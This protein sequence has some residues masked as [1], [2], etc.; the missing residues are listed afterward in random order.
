MNTDA[1]RTAEEPSTAF[2]A[3]AFDILGTLLRTADSPGTL[4]VYLTQQM[5]E[6][7]GAR[8]C[9]LLQSLHD[10]DE[11]GH[12]VVSVH[13]EGRGKLAESAEVRRLANLANDLEHPRLWSAEGNS[14]E[15]QRILTE[16]GCGASVAVPLNVG[17]IRVGILLLLDLPDT[18]SVS[19]MLGLLDILSTVVAL[20]LRNS[21][22]YLEQ[23][24]VVE[25]KTRELRESEQ[26]F[27][28]LVETSSDWIWEV[29][30][31]GRYTYASPKVKD[32][33]GYE[34]EEVIGKSP[35]DLM[36]PDEAERIVA[37]FRSLTAPQE[38]FARLENE[39]LRKDGTRVVLETSGVPVL[40]ANGDLLGY[41]GIDRDITERKRAEEARERL[42]AELGRSNTEL[43]EFAYAA[44]HDLQEPLRMVGSYMGLLE[45]RYKDKLDSDANEFIEF[46][47][48]GA[49]RMQQLIDD[50]LVYS[51]A[52][53]RGKTFEPVDVNGVVDEVVKNLEV[54]ITEH[55]ATV[56]RDEL[57]TVN[58][59]RT[60]LVQL[61]QNLVGNGI[62]FH[63][64]QPPRVHIWTEH[65]DR[66]WMFGVRDNG[67]G[68]D[69]K[70]QDR[71]FKVF[72][73][74]HTLEEYPGT[75][76]GLAVCRRIM[77]RH[78]GRIWV[79]SEPGKG[80]TF[81]FTLSEKGVSV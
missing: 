37:L 48:D 14:D 17:E 28:A 33:L 35:F 49:K 3:M 72:Q 30:E 25:Q 52:G 2:Q 26:R 10:F 41:R 21:L 73:R 42:V 59:D 71:I 64:H 53:T 5:R 34:P 61:V 16:L 65:S 68:I 78:G 13:P 70:Y 32:L 40:D 79:E 54:I 60:Q 8:T 45:R 62:K 22:L 43:E 80:A 57:P 29:D 51:R 44:S 67:I 56:T 18:H 31:K 75:G 63:G 47:V 76:V 15:A 7:T 55:N 46:A 50:L 69:R 36:P 6:L 77:D 9:V 11:S 4:G 38:P 66:G 27:R 24:Q 81:C 1:Q 23:E 39:G 19:Q 12:H 74:L 20:V 58:A